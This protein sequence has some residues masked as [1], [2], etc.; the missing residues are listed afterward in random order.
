MTKKKRKNN[1]KFK[2]KTVHVEIRKPVLENFQTGFYTQPD[3]P[4][5][6]LRKNDL[7]SRRYDGIEPWWLARQ[8]TN[9]IISR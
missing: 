2:N 9:K 7:F 1:E 5:A 3:V 8:E 4:E 6:N